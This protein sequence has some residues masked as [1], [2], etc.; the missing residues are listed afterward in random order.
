MFNVILDFVLVDGF[1]FAHG[2]NYLNG[3]GHRK[4][5]DLARLLFFILVFSIDVF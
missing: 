2:I 4:K 1:V 5:V 3:N